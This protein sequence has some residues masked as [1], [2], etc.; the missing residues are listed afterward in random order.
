QG[1]P[2]RGRDD[3]W[4]TTTPLRGGPEPGQLAFVFPGLEQ[5]FAS[6][7]DDIAEHWGLTRP[8]LGGSTALA[9]HPTGVLPVGHLLEAALGELGVAPDLVAG[10]SV[11]EWNAM[12]C[13]GIHPRQAVEQLIATFDP[14]TLRV[15][16]LV[17]AALGAGADR[18]TEAIGG[19]NRIVVSHD[20]CPHQSIICGE[21]SAVVAVL[22]RLQ[23]P[24]VTGQGLPFPA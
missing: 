8:R 5:D 17:F 2:W 4:F 13:A 1:S 11:G 3:I 18:A 9:P 14:A 20:N 16:G 24:G 6:R 23:A 21:E 10:H 22:N 15:P 19:A 12:T 7:V